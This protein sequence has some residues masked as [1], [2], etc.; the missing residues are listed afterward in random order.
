MVAAYADVCCA[1][2]PPGLLEALAAVRA[3][4]GVRVLQTSERLWVSWNGDERVLRAVMSLPGVVLYASRDGTWQRVGARLPAFE[5]PAEGDYR[6]LHDVLFPAPAYPLPAPAEDAQRWTKHAIRLAPDQLP[7]ATSGLLIGLDAFLAWADTVPDARLR[8]LRGALSGRELFVRGARLPLLPG[9]RRFWGERVLRPVG[10]RLEPDLPESIVREA[11]RV[12]DDELFVVH[13]DGRGEA[14]PDA[15]L[16]PL[17]RAALRR[18]ASGLATQE[19][20]A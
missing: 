11:G 1:S 3:V 16:Q 7:R 14:I 8:K 15:A 9:G 6:P 20:S 10:M 5:V 12:N 18:A 4:P 19:A 13:A 2:L 17:A